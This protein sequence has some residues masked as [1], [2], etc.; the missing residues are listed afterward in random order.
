VIPLLRVSTVCAWVAFATLEAGS[1]H[2]AQL[3][4]M[5]HRS[6]GS[7]A[8]EAQVS[9]YTAAPRT[10]ASAVCPSCYPDCQKRVKADGDGRFRIIGLD[11]SLTYRLLVADSR[12]AV[13][14]TDLLDPARGPSRVLLDRAVPIPRGTPRLAV[15]VVDEDSR[16]VFGA[17]VNV[18]GRDSARVRRFGIVPIDQPT[19]ITDRNGGAQFPLNRSGGTYLVK[20]MARDLA[21]RIFEGVAP[22]RSATLIMDGGSSVAGT[23]VRDGQPVAGSVVGIVQTD[24]RANRFL[25]AERIATDER[26]RFLFTNLP[27][28]ESLAVY[29]TM[30][31]GATPVVVVKSCG[32]G[33][34]T[35]APNLKVVSGATVRGRVV[36]PADSIPHGMRMSLFR[37]TAWDHASVMLGPSGEFHFEGV[38]R[39]PVELRLSSR[40]FRF[41][42]PGSDGTRS[43]ALTMT[44]TGSDTL[45]IIRVERLDR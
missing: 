37:P 34:V 13:K 42:S 11:D 18:F 5:A 23:V 27:P 8:A 43:D 36:F 41:I 33:T 9:I 2:A 38:P 22:E 24:R 10:G 35:R 6:D 12:S 3:I 25:G 4:G 44:P 28:D 16:P 26:G 15:R 21:P 20:L 45:L 1:L 39:E 32:V 30:A 7:P 14:I 40:D 31:S 29:G 17:T 19:A